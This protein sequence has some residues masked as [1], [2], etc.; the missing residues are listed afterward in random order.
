MGGDWR[1]VDE[2][3]NSRYGKAESGAGEGKYSHVSSTKEVKI[4][5]AR[6]IEGGN[7]GSNKGEIERRDSKLLL[8][9]VIRQA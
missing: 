4:S 8:H 2:E 6:K 5:D 1:Y 3:W 7:V 9:L